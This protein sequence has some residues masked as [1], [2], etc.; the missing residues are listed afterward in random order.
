MHEPGVDRNRSDTHAA[1][2]TCVGTSDPCCSKHSRSPGHL[3]FCYAALSNLSCSFLL[4]TYLS[5]RCRHPNSILDLHDPDLFE[6]SE[7]SPFSHPSGWEHY[8]LLASRRTFLS[9]PRPSWPGPTLLSSSRPHS[10]ASPF[11]SWSETHRTTPAPWREPIWSSLLRPSLLDL[12]TQQVIT[13]LVEMIWGQLLQHR[14]VGKL[15]LCHDICMAHQ[16]QPLSELLRRLWRLRLPISFPDLHRSRLINCCPHQL[17]LRVISWEELHQ[18]HRLPL[19]A[20]HL[21]EDQLHRRRSRRNLVLQLVVQLL[22]LLPQILSFYFVHR[23]RQTGQ[24]R[25]CFS[26]MP[27]LHPCLTSLPGVYHPSNLHDI[28]CS[29]QSQRPCAECP[30]ICPRITNSCKPALMLFTFALLSLP[31]T[32]WET[33]FLSKIPWKSGSSAATAV[34]KP[35]AV[36]RS[37]RAAITTAAILWAIQTT[38]A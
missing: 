11:A 17:C 3:A 20:L 19:S 8:M 26:L 23:A 13:K 6:A 9:L 15:Q 33:S 30:Y 5:S 10:S 28:S 36:V 14:F 24:R 34:A 1:F 7:T 37:G 31:W 27:R 35:S 38:R 25:L 16:L 18:W 12:F 32:S 22:E 29:V 2:H 4:W 21:I